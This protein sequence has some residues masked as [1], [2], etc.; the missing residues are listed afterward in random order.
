MLNPDVREGLIKSYDNLQ[1]EVEDLNK[2]LTAYRDTGYL[3]DAAS[4]A[5][6]DDL[7]RRI[8]VIFK[9]IDSFQE[10]ESK[11]V[12]DIS[13]PALKQIY[14][15][16]QGF[17]KRLEDVYEKVNDIR[18]QISSGKSEKVPPKEIQ[19]VNKRMGEV[20]ALLNRAP[21]DLAMSIEDPQVRDAALESI[22]ETHLVNNRHQEAVNILAK[23]QDPEA[24]SRMEMLLNEKFY[25][26]FQEHLVNKDF[27]A[28]EEVALQRL[29]GKTE[30]AACK[31]LFEASVDEQLPVQDQMGYANLISDPG[32]R[33]SIINEKY[34]PILERH[35]ANKDLNAAD[36]VASLW[37]RDESQASAFNLI[38]KLAREQ[39]LPIQDQ[40]EYAKRIPDDEAKKVAMTEILIQLEA[41]KELDAATNVARKLPEADKLHVVAK[42]LIARSFGAAERV[43]DSIKTP[44][45]QAKAA[46]LISYVR[47]R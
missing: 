25:P 44:E 2:A 14:T 26:I 6:K 13:S 36:E 22:F 15:G 16:E 19:E 21:V 35:L 45:G 30:E 27:K 1:A 29:Q 7:D 33:K 18:Y 32:T 17:K 43:A 37:L 3:P 31:A 24:K 12:Q 41:R 20:H 4:L 11:L 23:I 10:N 42:L 46:Q 38:F 47:N 40:M 39:H 8:A 5:Q 28:A 34:Y 9:S